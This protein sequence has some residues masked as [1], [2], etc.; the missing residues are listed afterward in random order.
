MPRTRIP[1]SGVRYSWQQYSCEAR[2][3]LIYNKLRDRHGLGIRGI[4]PVLLNSWE[5]IIHSR[6]VSWLVTWEKALLKGEPVHCIVSK[7]NR[8]KGQL[9]RAT[10][11]E[12]A[13]KA[14]CEQETFDWICI[15]VRS[16]TKLREALQ[17]EL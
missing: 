12:G 10:V 9:R 17:W 14:A 11:A 13:L 4:A 16:D 1:I 7:L 2:A 5:D 3:R 8:R 15:L 6:S